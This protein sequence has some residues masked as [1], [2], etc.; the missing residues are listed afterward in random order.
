MLIN[1]RNAP[2]NDFWFIQ[3]DTLWSNLADIGVGFNNRQKL[4]N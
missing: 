2:C 4:K 1:L 3:V